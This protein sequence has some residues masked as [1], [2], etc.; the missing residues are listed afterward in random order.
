MQV[1]FGSKNSYRKNRLI[2]VK[3]EENSN[4][5]SLR[6]LDSGM[7]K[8]QKEKALLNE[9]LWRMDCQ[10]LLARCWNLRDKEMVIELILENSDEWQHILRRESDV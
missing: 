8:D 3:S 9:D 6:S 1:F 7:S 2:K 5:I 4:P 10:R